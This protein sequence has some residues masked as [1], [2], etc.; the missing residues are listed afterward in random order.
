MLD[1]GMPQGL[2]PGVPQPIPQPRSFRK[3]QSITA[4][5]KFGN[6]PYMPGPD[7]PL[8]LRNGEVGPE[9]QLQARV[10]V[11][12]LSNTVDLKDFTDICDKIVKKTAILGTEERNWSE[13]RDT[14]VV[15]LRWYDRYLIDPKATEQE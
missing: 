9:E 13:K 1:Q 14:Y 7:G 4:S 12:D 5:K 15:L 10:R 11:F 6:L 2:M 3:D 8:T